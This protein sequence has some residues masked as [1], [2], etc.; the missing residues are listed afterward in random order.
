MTGSFK[1][2][3]DAKGRVAV[4]AKLR[5]ELGE[6][7]Y[8]TMGTNNCLSAYSETEWVRLKARVD[9]MPPAR[10]EAV[11]RMLF[12]NAETCEP[13]AQGRIILPKKLREYAKLERELSFNG[14]DDHAEIWN[15]ERWDAYNANMT[16]ED[17]AAALYE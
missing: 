4:P 2:V 9:N 6:R 16:A 10:A 7:F 1:C 5:T 13:D 14:V 11:K 8:V 17:L 12:P 15:G 3:L